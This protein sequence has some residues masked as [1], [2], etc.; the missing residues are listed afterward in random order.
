MNDIVLNTL[1]G[2]GG[3]FIA[4]V[5]REFWASYRDRNK[6]IASD[7]KANTLAIQT[8][9]HALVKLE[10]Q[11]ENLAHATEILPKLKA[12]VDI[13]HERVR[14]LQGSPSR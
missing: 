9:T 12:D 13:L 7:L 6:S 2:L 14:Q 5:L 10:V 3:A 4:W 1:F 8:N 11:I